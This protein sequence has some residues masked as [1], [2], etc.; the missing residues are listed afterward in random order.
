M[1]ATINTQKSALIEG[2]QAIINSFHTP[3]SFIDFMT[4]ALVWIHAYDLENQVSRSLSCHYSLIEILREIGSRWMDAKEGHEE[5]AIAEGIFQLTE[6]TN[7]EEI[8][9]MNHT[10]SL[11]HHLQITETSLTRETYLADAQGMFALIKIGEAMAGFEYATKLA[12][13]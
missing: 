8:I 12:G 13:E 5:A 11:A 2:A 10:I 6:N 3:K 1:Q 4:D 7:S 9:K